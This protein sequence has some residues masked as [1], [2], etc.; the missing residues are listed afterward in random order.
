MIGTV[1]GTSYITFQ[2]NTLTTR[3]PGQIITICQYNGNQSRE[4][5]SR[6]NSRNVFLSNIPQTMDNVQRIRLSLVQL[7]VIFLHHGARQ[8]EEAMYVH[9][10]MSLSISRG[11][12]VSHYYDQ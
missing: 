12:G 7:C 6:D 3:P 11:A 2:I 8:R 10:V 9:P 1:H 4:Y 5:G